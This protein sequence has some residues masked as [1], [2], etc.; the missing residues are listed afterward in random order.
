MQLTSSQQTAPASRGAN[1]DP[2]TYTRILIR[3]VTSIGILRRGFN[4]RSASHEP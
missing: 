1:G 4:V 2:R 3:F